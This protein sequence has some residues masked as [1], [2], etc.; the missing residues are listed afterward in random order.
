MTTK[1][2]LLV[3]LQTRVTELERRFRNMDRGEVF[4]PLTQ[5]DTAVVRSEALLHGV[6]YKLDLL[7]REEL[8]IF[9]AHIRQLLAASSSITRQ[10]QVQRVVDYVTAIR[11]IKNQLDGVPFRGLN[12]ADHELGFQLIRPQFTHDPDSATYRKNW[13]QPLLA[14]TWTPFIGTDQTAGYELGKDF[15]IVVTHATSL[16]TPKPF[17]TEFHTL[18]GRK[19]LA[20]IPMRSSMFRDTKNGTFV[21]PLPTLLMVPQSYWFVELLANVSGMEDLEMGGLVIGLGRVLGETA[22]SWK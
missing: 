9:N 10:I 8:G 6:A 3:Q 15:G 22:P 18:V 16:V 13:E 19:Y 17:V 20:P 5:G 14:K 21:Y 7:D 11:A 1:E 12:P 4:H 2:E